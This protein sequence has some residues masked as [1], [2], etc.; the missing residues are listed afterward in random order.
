MRPAAT[1]S[2]MAPE[3]VRADEGWCVDFGNRRAA[4][5]Y[6]SSPLVNF[7]PG[8]RP[9]FVYTGLAPLYLLELRH[10]DGDAATWF[11]DADMNR[12]SDRVAELPS[13]FADLISEAGADLVRKILR[14]TV[15]SA[16]PSLD[17]DLRQFFAVNPKIRAEL[18]PLCSAKCSF[19]H[20]LIELHKEADLPALST[21]GLSLEHLANALQCDPMSY[22]DEAVQ[23]QR[24][25]WPSPVSDNLVSTDVGI[26]LRTG[27]AYRV[28]DLEADALFYAIVSRYN[29]P[30]TFALYHPKSN[31]IIT[32]NQRQSHLLATNMP[33]L[34]QP[35]AEHMFLYGDLFVAYCR[36]P[37][38]S[39]SLMIEAGFD[40][41]IGTYLWHQLSGVAEL[42]RRVP[43]AAIPEIVVL[44]N[45]E[46]SEKFGKLDELYPELTGK[47]N[48]ELSADADPADHAYRSG[49]LLVRIGDH[50]VTRDLATRIVAVNEREPGLARERERY[51]RLR[52][53]GGPI[54]ALGLRTENRTVVDFPAFCV[55]LLQ[56]M[57]RR[58]PRLTVVVDGHNA[59]DPAAQTMLYPSHFENLAA[60]SPV[61][62]EKQIVERLR[63]S[64]GP[65][66]EV[67]DNIGATISTSIFWTERSDFFV[68][69]WGA[70]L[71]KGRWVCNKP[72]IVISSKWNLRQRHDLHIYDEEPDIEA[73]APM[74]FVGEEFVTDRPDAPVLFLGPNFSAESN[75]SFE[76]YDKTVFDAV[77]DFL[78]RYSG[79]EAAAISR[80]EEVV[81][82]AAAPRP[83][84]A[85]SSRQD[86]GRVIS[87]RRSR[88]SP[89]A[90]VAE[91]P[92]LGKDEYTLAVTRAG[93]RYQVAFAS[94][95][96][97]I[98]AAGEPAILSPGWRPLHVY[99]GFAPIFLVEL[100]HDSGQQ[101]TWFLD[102]Q[103]DR[104][105][106][107][108]EELP[109]V[110]AAF[111]RQQARPLIQSIRHQL[112]CVEHP[113][114]DARAR[115][116]FTVN[117]ATRLALLECCP[118]PFT[119]P[120]QHVNLMS[121]PVSELA[122]RREFAGLAPQHLIAILRQDASVTND[123]AV[124]TGLLSWPS[125]V[126]GAP[127][128]TNKMICLSYNHFA[129]RL[130]DRNEVF[131][132]VVYNG[133]WSIPLMVYFP[134]RNCAFALHD[135][136]MLPEFNLSL[137]DLL[138]RHLLLFGDDI[139]RFLNSNRT[140]IAFPMRNWHIGHH[141]WN[142]L[143]EIDRLRER[144]GVERLPE[145]LLVGGAR[146][147]IYGEI[148]ALFPE[149]QG[150]V[151]H[152]IEGHEIGRYVYRD[153]RCLLG[154]TQTPISR[155]LAER[156]LRLNLARPAIDED[157]R[158]LERFR[159]RGAYPVVL[160]GLRMQNRTLV[161]L[162]EFYGNI[163]RYLLAKRGAALVVFDG[164]NA[165]TQS[166][167]LTAAEQRIV[168]EL[169]EEFADEPVEIVS[170]IGA[171]MARSLFWAVHADFF[172]A[173]WGAGMAKYCW[174]CKKPGLAVTS[175]WN[176][177]NRDDLD[178]YTE[179]SDEP[180][181]VEFLP[182]RYVEDDRAAPLLVDDPAH[183]RE[184]IMNFRVDMAGVYP[185][186][187]R[188]LRHC[189]PSAPSP[190][191]LPAEAHV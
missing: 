120:A 33:S 96:R 1:V 153:S 150:K 71:A 3:I 64:F 140:T 116:L 102:A 123:S 90:I 167:D 88:T 52:A 56:H 129:Y 113:Q 104:I 28:Y 57:L 50:R 152:R 162:G 143:S 54:V 70:W 16:V 106:G 108:V 40:S 163:I 17:D 26:Y 30:E 161:D 103:L 65:E 97:P 138:L 47:L 184:S 44:G 169:R 166:A 31:S 188:L 19:E 34:A 121:A 43:P 18:F 148:D 78:V 168:D 190:L 139:E 94:G 180:V 117:S 156:I 178:I 127:V 74:F 176:L 81:P 24:L 95:P 77:D 141:L 185:I 154:P 63:S 51:A 182:E 109:P 172:I 79:V 42:V 187:E 170:T 126:D 157:R 130:V 80:T 105:A 21:E 179:Y 36:F 83:G 159:A 147:E 73:P 122:R 101:A 68:A 75:Y 59:A 181:A 82:L 6:D 62:L 85:A 20:N 98:L 38:R 91:K 27:V 2:Q 8:W 7:V 35:L 84:P 136:P 15:L 100:R 112:L 142:E 165:R 125:P 110:A 137:D 4:I 32:L 92:V 66:L 9:V 119:R 72:G 189:A 48:R 29:V 67:V 23:A 25:H 41:H 53:R 58:V 11:L 14:H 158:T 87:S 174:I 86:V 175:R 61:E 133:S 134:G 13:A 49:K 132:V 128:A 99:A 146:A 45:G 46:G 89:A 186:L 111:L 149:L 76:V 160:L 10:D 144:F 191:P 39:L 151:E 173:P 155:Q 135:D 69:P 124:T 115:A 164:D 55:R 12:L 5:K 37:R 114:L 131:Y 171:P 145:V 118:S 93:G 60:I 22:L 107:S 177:N 183:A